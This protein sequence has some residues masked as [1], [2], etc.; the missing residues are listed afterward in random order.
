MD[1]SVD[2]ETPVDFIRHAVDTL[3]GPALGRVLMPG[4]ARSDLPDCPWI[5]EDELVE[6][7]PS[8]IR[9]RKRYLTEGERKRQKKR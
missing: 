4:A 1:D 9:A 5:G 8:A 2:A 6:I 7:T 3:L